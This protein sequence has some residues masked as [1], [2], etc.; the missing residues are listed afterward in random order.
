MAKS[1]IS[2]LG[3]ADAL[4][5]LAVLDADR[6]H[7]PVDYTTTFAAETQLDQANTQ[8]ST[9]SA[10]PVTT[11]EPTQQEAADDN[12][13]RACFALLVLACLHTV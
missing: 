13:V 3:E 11:A 12:K 8:A 2:E 5:N 1:K 6:Y 4:Q 7:R 10:A 9:V